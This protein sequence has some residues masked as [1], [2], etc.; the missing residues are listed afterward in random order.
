[1]LQGITLHN[2]TFISVF[3]LKIPE[4]GLLGQ[5]MFICNFYNYY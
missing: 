5:S 1:M 3:V 4:N 2:H